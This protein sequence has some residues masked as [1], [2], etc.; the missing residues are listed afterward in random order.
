MTKILFSIVVIIFSIICLAQEPTIGLLHHDINASKGYTLFT[1]EKSTSVF[2]INNCGELVNQWEFSETPG[3]TCYFL[4]NGNLLRVGKDS[5]EIRDWDSNQIWSYATTD[6]G[7]AA[8]HDIHPLPNG[9]VL[10]VAS[11]IY[12]NTDIAEEGRDPNNTD[13]TFKLDRII[14]LQ[15]VGEHDAHIVWEW[16]FIDHMIQDF[17]DTK[18]NFGVVEDYPE[19]LDLN[20]E[21]GQT[22][23]WTHVNGIEYNEELDQILLTARHLSEIYIIDHS[24]TTLE[25]SGHTGG[26][27]GNGG[28]FIWRWGNPQVYRQ[29]DSNDR[30]LTWPHDA[31]WVK[32]GYLD[33][34]KISIF[35]N[36]FDGT[37]D[38]SFV[39]LILPEVDG[40]NYITSENKFLP[41]DYD[42]SWSGQILGGTMFAQLKSGAHSL[43]NGNFIICQYSSCIISEITKSGELLWA[44]K[45]PIGEIVFNQFQIPS[46]PDVGIFRGEKYPLDYAG[47]DGK[48]LSPM[49]I[50]ENT[51]ANSAACTSVDI[52]S[53]A[54]L[55]KPMILNNI[56]SNSQI[57]FTT[58]FTADLIR[59][60]GI[61][62]KIHLTKSN[63]EGQLLHV[64][65]K[66]GIYLVQI[67]NGKSIKTE[68][69]IV[70]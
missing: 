16:K 66:K 43:P 54:M 61:D 55:V 21:N 11:D 29:G 32:S 38:E 35:N 70:Q 39:H 49:G 27:S 37:G 62:S 3:A 33:E 46:F 41:L 19:L 36:N 34:G 50:L 59:I 8:H 6:N 48:D 64:N 26:N 1:P 65:L 4:E 40:Y 5:I 60:I 57:E 10:C 56:I 14:E 23:D 53:T 63:F 47:F 52:E 31:K 20:F 69:F 25:A 22:K 30:K 44:Y 28:D 51:N 9:N 15:P 12:T 67:I 24:T 42:W 13:A 58:Y 68:K 2:L 45:N 18:D 7:I 17:D